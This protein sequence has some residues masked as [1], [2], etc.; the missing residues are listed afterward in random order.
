MTSY[1]LYNSKLKAHVLPL[2]EWPN[3]KYKPNKIV[4]DSSF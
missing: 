1:H 2:L 3:T 4:K